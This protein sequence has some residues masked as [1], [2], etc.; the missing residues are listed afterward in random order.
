MW[1]ILPSN[2]DWDCFKTLILREISRI[3]NPLLQEHCAFL[4]VKYLFQKFGC[5]KN[6]LQFPQNPKSSLWTLDWDL[7]GF[8]LSNC[9]IWLLLFWE[10]RLRPQ[11]ERADLLSLTEVEHLKGRSSRW[12]ILIV[13]FQTSSLRFKKLDCMCSKTVKR[14]S[15]W[16]LKEGVLQLRHVFRIHRVALDWVF[17]RIKLDTKN[18]IQV[19][20]HQKRTR[21]HSTQ[22]KFHTWWV[23]SFVVFVQYQPFQFYSLFRSNGNKITTSFRRRTSHSKIET[24][25]EPFFARAP[26][27]VSSSTSVSLEKRSYGSQDPWSSIVTKEDRSGRL[28]IGMDRMKVSDHCHHEQFIE[29]F[30]S[31][32]YSKTDDD[33]AWS[34]QGW[35]TFIETC[36]WSGRFDEISWRMIRKFRPGFSHEEI[37]LDATSKSVR[38]EERPRDRSV[39]PHIN[40]H[41]KV[42]P[43][44]FVIGKDETDLEL[45]VES[46]SFV[47][48]VNDQVRKRQK[49]ISNVTEDGEKHSMIWWMFMIVTVEVAV[50]MGKNFLNTC[51]SIAN[52]KDLTLKHMFD[53]STRWC[54]SKMRSLDWF[55]ESVMEILVNDWWRKNHQSSTHEGLRL[56][57]FCP[58]TPNRTMHGNKD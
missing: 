18:S 16:S 4:E 13:F 58:R 51:Q 40:S 42:R 25:D 5:V 57:R 11:R 38:N 30:S 31:A 26:S 2:A 50:F 17:D 27:R 45:S 43:P 22:R 12:L 29:S 33:R 47:N 19:H 54:L 3:Q 55:W 36:E 49:R 9:G 53:T 48:R 24:N 21:K 46:R 37:L 44:Q 52:T 35:K 41:E 8:L 10:T 34:S 14:W 28:D 39:R 6:K 20:R 7:T 1:E 15:R 23:E 56:F 32:S